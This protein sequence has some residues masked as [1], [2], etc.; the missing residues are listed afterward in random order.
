MTA[1]RKSDKL[2]FFSFGMEG[3]V[4]S[5]SPPLAIDAARDSKSEFTKPE[6][7]GYCCPIERRCGAT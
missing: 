3:G 5:S 2:E 1:A 6:V 7:M 4:L